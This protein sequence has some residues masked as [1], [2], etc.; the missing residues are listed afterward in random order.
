MRPVQSAAAMV[1]WFA[2]SVGAAH[3]S[4][5]AIYD[6][7]RQTTLTA[8]VR[9]FRFVNP[10]PWVDVETLD[11]SG[12]QRQWKLE[13]DNR[14]EL[15]Q[16]GM[17]ADTLRPGDRLIVSGRPARDG[18]FALYVRRLERPA[19]GLVYEQ[20]GMTPTLTGPKRD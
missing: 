5:V 14:F 12:R 19:D 13:M 4:T 7:T 15:V 11:E 20:E 8:V 9:A 17:T 1:F 10:H 3:H 2:A 6:S 16:I 18:S